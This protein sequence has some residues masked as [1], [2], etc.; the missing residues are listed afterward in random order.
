MA[1]LA[2]RSF[3]SGGRPC[4]VSVQSTLC[5][6]QYVGRFIPFSRFLRIMY[7]RNPIPLREILE[8]IT[9]RSLCFRRKLGLYVPKA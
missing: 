8:G 6:A 9:G 3:E 1:N 2:I 5:F 4:W 7:S